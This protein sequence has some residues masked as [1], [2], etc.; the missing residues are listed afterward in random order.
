VDESPKDLL[1]RVA[2]E[3]GYVLAHKRDDF[4]IFR[5]DTCSDSMSIR[6][7]RVEMHLY[8]SGVKDTE[9]WLRKQFH[10]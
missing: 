8:S 1:F 5:S 2:G 6:L 4:F 3:C 9:A 7:D 10:Q